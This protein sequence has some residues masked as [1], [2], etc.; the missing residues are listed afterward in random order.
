MEFDATS[1]AY[2]RTILRSTIERCPFCE[3]YTKL[4]FDVLHLEK[5]LNGGG[6]GRNVGAFFSKK[7]PFLAFW[8]TLSAAL[9]FS[10]MPWPGA[11]PEKV[12]P[13]I[14][15]IDEAVVQCYVPVVKILL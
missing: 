8:P 9:D 1:R 2:S 15:F 4:Y 10:N 3:K 13:D 11:F 12:T 5:V 6:G 7:V 14:N